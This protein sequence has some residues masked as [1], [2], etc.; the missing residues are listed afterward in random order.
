MVAEMV[1]IFKVLYHIGV[2]RCFITSASGLFPQ[3]RDEWYCSRD[4][5]IGRMQFE[6]HAA[7]HD[8][9]HRES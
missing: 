9:A 1:A 7:A 5:M 4:S 6:A 3:A 2:S 8:C